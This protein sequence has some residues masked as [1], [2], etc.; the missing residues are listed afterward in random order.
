MTC[1]LLL[2]ISAVGCNSIEMATVFMVVTYFNKRKARAIAAVYIGLSVGGFLGAPLLN[3]LFSEYGFSGTM[4]IQSGIVLNCCITAS[5]S[6]PL[7]NKRKLQAQGKV[8]KCN[9]STDGEDSKE[10]VQL[11]DLN[12]QNASLESED[13]DCH[14]GQYIPD[15]INSSNPSLDLECR[16]SPS[17]H[18]IYC[19]CR[20]IV[21]TSGLYLC[22]NVKFASQC[23]L[24][25][26]FF[27][28][29]MCGFVYMG[30]LAKE[31]CQMTPGDIALVVSVV[32]IV[33]IAARILSG[34]LFDLKRLKYH[35][36][37]LYGILG[38]TMGIIFGI[39]P[40][41][42]NFYG[43]MIC[44]FAH[45]TCF[46]MFHT[47]TYIIMGDIVGLGS[48]NS[49]MGISRVAM[50]FGSMIGATIPGKS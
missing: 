17:S 6:R 20:N 29:V 10:P 4:M 27:S 37:T 43:F 49:A 30:P 7:N 28:V 3:Y 1:F 2:V 12:S 8:E 9:Q 42:T 13:T 44:W 46:V 35:R 41:A 16:T 22:K 38:I 31:T 14:K 32:S 19:S 23:L 39:L 34:I 11:K 40:F 24:V 33:E 25:C 21:A 36:S 48:L 18:R 15:I 26:F 47:H 50:G 5:L 45:M